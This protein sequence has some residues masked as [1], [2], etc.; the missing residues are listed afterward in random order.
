MSVTKRRWSLLSGLAIGTLFLVPSATLAQDPQPI[1][2]G[3]G[4]A[5]Y[6]NP[7][8]NSTSAGTNTTAQ[9]FFHLFNDTPNPVQASLDCVSSGSVIDCAPVQCLRGGCL[10][11]TSVEVPANGSVQITTQ[12]TTGLVGGTGGVGLIAQ[13][14][15]EWASA[16]YLVTVGDP[17]PPIVDASMNPGPNMDRSSCVTAGAGPAGA[18]QCGELL[19]AHAMPA[20]RTRSRERTLTLLYTSGSARPYPLVMADVHFPAGTVV[21]D[22]VQVKLFVNGIE[23]A[24]HT[25]PGAQFEGAA[26]RRVAVG[27]DA[28]AAGLSTG[29]Y[30]YHLEVSG[31]Y[32]TSQQGTT[33]G[34]E[35]TIVNRSQNNSYGAGWAVAGVDQLY[36]GQAGRGAILL[37][38]GDG[39]TRLYESIGQDQ[40]LA[41]AGAYRDTIRYS[42]VSDG[43]VP[44]GDY[45]W[46]RL[47]NRT[48][49]FFNERGKQKWVVDREGHKVEYG[50]AG[51]GLVVGDDSPGAPLEYVQIAPHGAG[52]RYL[53]EYNQPSPS[54]KQIVDP[55]GRVLTATWE[56]GLLTR[57]RDPGRPVGQ[58]VRFSYSGTRMISWRSPGGA[59][60][61][62]VYFG[63]SNLL[64][65]DTLPQTQAGRAVNQY[66]AVQSR[67]LATAPS[68]N[69]SVPAD[70][71]FA[72]VIGPRTDVAQRT[73]F[74]VNRHGAP[75]RIVDA[76]GGVTEIA[77]DTALHPLL[78]RRIRYPNAR[79][80]GVGYDAQTNVL[81]VAD[82]THSAGVATT[83]YEYDLA[84]NEVSKITTPNGTQTAFNYNATNGR[85]TWMRDALGNQTDYRYYESGPAL[86]LVRAIVDPGAVVPDSFEYNGLGNLARRLSQRH[87]PA[88]P[89]V[90]EYGYNDTTQLTLV[91][92]P[93]ALETRN[94][95]SPR[96]QLLSRTDIRPGLTAPAVTTFEHDTED[97]LW[98]RTDPIGVQYLWEYDALGRTT[99]AIDAAQKADSMG[100]DLAGNM[101]VHRTRRGHIVAQSYDAANRL[102][103]KIMPGFSEPSMFTSLGN[104]TISTDTAFFAYDVAGNIVTARNRHSRVGRVFSKEGNLVSDTLRI[105][106]VANPADFTGHVYTWQFTYDRENR[107]LTTHYPHVPI[108]NMPGP[109]TY[110]YGGPGHADPR[111]FLVGMTTPLG[112]SFGLSYDDHGRLARID[113][114]NH[115]H[116]E[117]RYYPDHSLRA[118]DART[119][120]TGS[121]P[122]GI[123]FRD[124]L[125]RN[126][127][128]HITRRDRQ[129]LGT[130]VHE[131]SYG[132]DGFQRLKSY[133][134]TQ[135]GGGTEQFDY[136]LAGN[137]TEKISSMGTLEQWE[138]TYQ[139][140]RLTV[141]KRLHSG[142]WQ[143]HLAQVWDHAG[144][145]K[146]RA[147]YLTGMLWNGTNL[148]A[149]LIQAE[150][151]YFYSADGKLV[152]SETYRPEPTAPRWGTELAYRYDALG[153]RIMEWERWNLGGGGEVRRH[154]YDGQH[155]SYE[156][157]SALSNADH[158][159][160]GG[161]HHPHPLEDAAIFRYLYGDSAAIYL[162]RDELGNVLAATSTTG[163]WDG[164]YAPMA[165]LTGYRAYGEPDK[166]YNDP[167][168]TFTG[169]E[170]SDGLNGGLLYLR[171]RYYDPNTGRFTQEDPI[172]FAGGMNLYAYANNNP[173]TYT[174]PFGLSPCSRLV[175]IA[176]TV[177][178]LAAQI[179]Q[180]F[181]ANPAAATGSPIDR[182]AIEAT[183]R[184]VA[185]TTTEASQADALRHVKRAASRGAQVQVPQGREPPRLQS[186]TM[187]RP[188]HVTRGATGFFLRAPV[189][190]VLLL[191]Q[192]YVDVLFG[193]D[194]TI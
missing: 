188:A 86:G 67:G 192:S 164:N 95:Y 90:W 97:R 103:R 3:P 61:K 182:L 56:G 79:V 105:G 32:P 185:S 20:Y 104:I 174:D 180:T 62:Y 117:Y 179:K 34:G 155:R 12:F 11:L 150:T 161:I 131:H 33:E 193:Q 69:A 167:G 162:H 74:W 43:S 77:Y 100:Y 65:R 187:R 146:D 160:Q 153:R 157:K 173:A 7:E 22:E 73:T 138:Y 115:T 57:L 178:T 158:V 94:T 183:A 38:G 111:G 84:W 60:T 116:T 92:Q 48:R 70:S 39:S 143:N 55:A 75:T 123:L 83:T 36:F 165:A 80:V 91:R 141:G 189:T 169:R 148:V 107:R 76:V 10:P 110:S 6:F 45:Y 127:A 140:G 171:N 19:V 72:R 144:N 108:L 9:V 14:G 63:A 23:R 122:S 35:F 114:P 177:M 134:R 13:G 121:I 151:R 4:C 27:F 64:A 125:I 135:S 119:G 46:T 166:P 31:L 82:S 89:V 1:C 128:S 102:I 190:G 8:T 21:P 120:N 172:G 184:G 176:C 186:Q 113:Y 41:P 37:V 85:R 42:N 154:L 26:K 49:V 129:Q 28:A 139:A 159:S 168:D 132:Y 149:G 109:T 5:L 47:K 170:T 30:E 40:W 15:G 126:V 133:G 54:L 59:T 181:T 78:A 51:F 53:F 152:R 136:D 81:W 156:L 130:T 99:R 175:G 194:G 58:E 191:P 142:S 50:Y 25:Y 71:A 147:G 163:A 66:I 106:R 124:S 145:L 137:R 96:N 87:T 18:F 88:V 118:A 112:K 52:K 16:S 2:P 98:R 24:A 93:D 17:G 101:T 29:V 68:S 44:E